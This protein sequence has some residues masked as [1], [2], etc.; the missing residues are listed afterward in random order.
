MSRFALQSR[1]WLVDE[2]YTNVDVTAGL[3]GAVPEES[4]ASDAVGPLLAVAG[5]LIEGALRDVSV[6]VA[7]RLLASSEVQQLWEEA[8]RAAH[9]LLVAVIDEDAVEGVT[10]T[11]NDVILD[12]QPLLTEFA[13]R[14][15]ADLSGVDVPDDFGQITVLETD[16]LSSV[17]SLVK[18]LKVMS[19]L[20]TLVVIGLFGLAI[21]LARGQRRRIVSA[22]AAIM[23]LVGVALLLI[24]AIAGNAFVEALASSE[25]NLEPLTLVWGIGT[26]LL[27]NI[28]TLL[29]VYGSVVLVGAWLGGPSRAAVALRRRLAPTISRAPTR[30]LCSRRFPATPRTALVAERHHPRAHWYG[31]AGWR[32]HAR[33]SR[34]SPTD[35][36]GIPGHPTRTTRTRFR[37]D[38][39]VALD[40]RTRRINGSDR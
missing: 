3:Q 39:G 33:R 29:I 30:R 36:P 35:G 34:T 20:L 8:N 11:D 7:E 24:Q 26:K 14:T 22:C 37:A 25:V 23:L 2:L 10:V 4:Q 17:Q 6:G 38:F 13:D 21:Y 15:G 27:V 32:G 1:V 18:A 19:S 40:A 5:P 16:Q 9:T 31:R 28:A 12:L